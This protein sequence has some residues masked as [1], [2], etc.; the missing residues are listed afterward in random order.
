MSEKCDPGNPDEYQVLLIVT[1]GAITDLEDTI[2]AV[3]KA[4]KMPLSIIIVGVG[5]ADF[6]SME[7]LDGDSDEYQFANLRDC[8]QFVS[9]KET[10]DMY[11]NA[12]MDDV[13]DL[14]A[15]FHGVKE[16]LAGR[17]LEELPKQVEDYMK[18]Q[19]YDE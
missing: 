10:E 6:S 9:F 17:L 19:G 11:H 1:D 15:R 8:V 5:D 4:Q 2:R 3:D 16:L 14:A 12:G 7:I 13:N 18:L